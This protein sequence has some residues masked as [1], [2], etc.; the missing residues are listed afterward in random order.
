MSSYNGLQNA[1]MRKRNNYHVVRPGAF[2][3][4]SSEIG[5]WCSTA[6]HRPPT[7]AGT[8]EGS[9]TSLATRSSPF[10]ASSSTATTT[11]SALT[12]TLDLVLFDDV[13]Q[14][15]VDFVGHCCS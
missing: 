5:P 13:V 1:T 10:D 3:V 7:P 8:T 4:S 11:A 9:C 6:P 15:H 2:G 14:A 12:S